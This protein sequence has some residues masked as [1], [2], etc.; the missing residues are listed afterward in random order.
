MIDYA[1]LTVT[2]TPAYYAK[3]VTIKEKVIYIVNLL[4]QKRKWCN[5][6]P[7]AFSLMANALAYFTMLFV[8]FSD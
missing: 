2:S 7:V 1:Y 5:L 4:P 8:F 6:N 3:A